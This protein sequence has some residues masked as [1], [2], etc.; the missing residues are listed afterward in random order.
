[1]A[2]ALRRILLLQNNNNHDEFFAK[3]PRRSQ[4]VYMKNAP[5]VLRHVS[6]TVAVVRSG[7]SGKSGCVI[8]V[9]P[10]AG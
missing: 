9:L 4:I 7:I 2:L 5:L 10:L 6:R 3:Y 1:M 8:V